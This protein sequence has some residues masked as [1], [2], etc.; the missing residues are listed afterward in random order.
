MTVVV[1]KPVKHKNE[2]KTIPVKLGSPLYFSGDSV[3]KKMDFAP[4]SKEVAVETWSV[5]ETRRKYEAVQ[6]MPE[7]ERKKWMGLPDAPKDPNTFASVALD[8]EVVFGSLYTQE[9]MSGALRPPYEPDRLAELV[10][11]N[12]TLQSCIDA[13]VTNVDGTGYEVIEDED[14]EQAIPDTVAVALKKFFEQPWPGTTFMS[15][16][17]QLRRDLET[18]GNAYIEVIRNLEGQIGLIR[19]MDP[20]IT[21]IM[22]LGHDTFEEEIWSPVLNTN[23]KVQVRRRRY[24]QYVFGKLVYFREFGS[25]MHLNRYNGVWEDGAGAD[26][27]GPGGN[28]DINDRATEV[29]HLTCIPHHIPP[30]GIPR[31]VHQIPSVIGSRRAEEWNLGFFEQG[32]IP[33]MLIVIQGGEA[34]DDVEEAI[35]NLFYSA[36]PQKTTAAILQVQNTSGDLNDPAAVKVTVERFGS[37]RQKDQMFA[38]YDKNCFDKIRRAWRIPPMFVGEVQGFNYATALASYRVAEAQVFAPERRDFDEMVTT[39]VL[40]DIVG[41]K[42]KSIVRFRSLPITAKDMDNQLKALQMIVGNQGMPNVITPEELIDNLNEVTGLVLN[43]ATPEERAEMAQEKMLNA[44][45]FGQ[46]QPNIEE[47]TGAQLEGS[48][49]KMSSGAGL[50]ETL[51]KREGARRIIMRRPVQT[52]AKKAEQ[53]EDVSLDDEA[54]RLEQAIKNGDVSGFDSVEF[55][56]RAATRRAMVGKRVAKR[57]FCC[58]PGEEDAAGAAVESL[59]YA[60]K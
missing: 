28:V 48:G 60:L 38:N 39:T 36:G 59:L 41:D 7:E 42:V 14:S 46:P 53:G 58:K 52:P 1:K 10:E 11:Q 34:A 12:N 47:G 37:D 43:A 49:G 3:Q 30:Y 40:R 18:T 56:S 9:G 22:R 6:R 21:R 55:M 26:T 35:K 27:R 44:A 8:R 24:V 54:G 19:R 16:R 29:I 50:E 32:G 4:I 45:M 23:I 5:L 51:G 15:L 20:Y 25:P 33:P 2:I 57:L 31:W 17:K 13:M